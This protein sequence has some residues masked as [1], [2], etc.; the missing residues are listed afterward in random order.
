MWA[1]RNKVN[2]STPIARNIALFS[3]ISLVVVL[4]LIYNSNG[5]DTMTNIPYHQTALGIPNLQANN[6]NIS[7]SASNRISSNV[8]PT[9][10]HPPVVKV[11]PDQTVNE[12]ATVMLVGVAIDPEPDDKVSYSW[13]QVAGP[14]ITLNGADTDTPSFDAPSNLLSDTP[15]KFTLTA[16]DDKG[17]ESTIPATVTNLVKHINHPPIANAN[18]DQTVNAGYVVSLDGSKSKDPDNDPISYS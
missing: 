10:N 3:I 2:I 12:S 4:A 1:I 6:T 8:V 18:Q 11:G 17:A 9:A 16:K 14:A 5:F 13:M 7:S 15:L